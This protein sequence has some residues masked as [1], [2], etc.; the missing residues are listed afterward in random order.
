MLQLGPMSKVRSAPS[1]RNGVHVT[2]GDIRVRLSFL[3]ATFK[4][5]AD[6]TNSGGTSLVRS[7][8]HVTLDVGL[9]VCAPCWVQTLLKNKKPK[10]KETYF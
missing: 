7:E 6:G 9:C 8:E 3:V 1:G 2:N 10:L 5:E 4:R